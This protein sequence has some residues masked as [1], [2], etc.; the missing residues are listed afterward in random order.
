MAATRLLVITF[1]LK[2]P[3]YANATNINIA[4]CLVYVWGLLLQIP[5]WLFY[6]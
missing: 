4:I 6:R 1:P 3:T 2:A 5:N